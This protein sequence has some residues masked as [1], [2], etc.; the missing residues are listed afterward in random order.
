EGLGEILELELPV[1]LVIDLFPHNE[2][3]KFEI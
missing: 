3:L 2:Y 1:E